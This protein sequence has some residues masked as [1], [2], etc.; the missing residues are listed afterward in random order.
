MGDIINRLKM[1]RIESVLP[2]S[3]K[4][5]IHLYRHADRDPIPP[6][7]HHSMVSINSAGVSNARDLGKSLQQFNHIKI[8]S[9]PVQRCT[10]TAEAI[11]MGFSGQVEIETSTLLG[12][13][14]AFVY[15]RNQARRHFL[16]MGNEKVLEQLMR[17]ETLEGMYSFM[18]GNN[19]FLAFIEEQ[20]KGWIEGRGLIMITHDFLQAAL[21][22]FLLGAGSLQNWPDFL[23][24]LYLSFEVEGLSIN[25]REVQTQLTSYGGRI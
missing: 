9:S 1:E 19:R 6:G 17:G 10:Q 23:E 21:I 12:S 5:T 7:T 2:L 24:G 20:S 15:D 11:A 25:W 4:A 18:V 14:G 8:V 3:T 16:E 22:S 13:P